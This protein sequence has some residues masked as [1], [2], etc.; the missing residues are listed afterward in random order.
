MARNCPDCRQ[1]LKTE[2]FHNIFVEVCADCEGVWFDADE[3]KRLLA[4]DPIALTALEER[5]HP[6]VTQH[7]AHQGVLFC[8]GCDGLLHVYHYQYDSPIELQACLDCG[9][10]WV[11]EKQLGK[12][13]Q[14]LQAHHHS[15]TTEEKR[16]R[17]LAEATMEH[18]DALRR[19][20]RLNSF[21]SLLRRHQPQWLA[22]IK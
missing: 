10:F 12:M 19:Q 3:I 21:L 15:E 6:S 9:G 8:P 2:S 11:E 1:T 22:G 16:S 4:A 13:Q 20:T 7:K 17:M 14:W 18:D 5:C